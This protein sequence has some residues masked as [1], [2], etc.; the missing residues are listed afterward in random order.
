MYFFFFFFEFRPIL[1]YTHKI[2][3]SPAELS[4][5]QKH[6]FLFI[7]IIIFFCPPYKRKHWQPIKSTNTDLIKNK[8]ITRT[9]VL[10]FLC[11]VVWMRACVHAIVYACKHMTIWL[12]ITVYTYFLSHVHC[13]I[14]AIKPKIKYDETNQFRKINVHYRHMHATYRD[15]YTLPESLKNVEREVRG[16]PI[17]FYMLYIDMQL[18]CICRRI[19]MQAYY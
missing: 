14:A 15:W 4:S 10:L 11:I 8:F 12:H 18:T 9:P 5:P 19:R 13:T 16:A 6:C 1:H 3:A 7:F 2:H 17:K